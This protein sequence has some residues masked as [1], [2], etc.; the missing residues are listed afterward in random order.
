MARSKAEPQ[1]ALSA[2]PEVRRQGWTLFHTCPD[3]G[4]LVLGEGADACTPATGEPHDCETARDQY[5]A[6]GLTYTPF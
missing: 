1:A 4:T 3:C 6:M 2:E 5:Q